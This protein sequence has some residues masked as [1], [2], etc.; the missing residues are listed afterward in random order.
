MK[1]L[2]TKLELFSL[3]NL[4]ST[5]ILFAVLLCLPFALSAQWTDGGPYIKTNDNVTIGT[6]NNT[7][8]F[9]ARK[10]KSGWQGRFANRGG[11]GADIYLAHGGGYGMHIRGW[12]TDGKY[13]LQLHNANAQTNV[14]YNNGKVGLGLVGKVGVGTT[15]PTQK[16]HVTGNVLSTGQYIT[17]N[18]NSARYVHGNYGIIHRNDGSNYWILLT[19]SGDQ[20]GGWNTL[21]PFRI[22]NVN[23]DVHIGPRQRNQS[24]IRLE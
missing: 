11:A 13:T 17:T 14:F 18:A 20:Y 3:L 22:N 2:K 15:N 12:T 24:R 16:L 6:N 4:I 1:T 21:R 8:T 10:N 5:K 19:A 23:G 7:F 9:Y